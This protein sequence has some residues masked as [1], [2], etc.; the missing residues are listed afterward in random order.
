MP[1]GQKYSFCHPVTD[2]QRGEGDTYSCFELIVHAAR[3]QT[4]P[5][6]FDQDRFIAALRWARRHDPD[7]SVRE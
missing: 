5:L 4:P 6:M 1:D 7:W 3:C 2:D